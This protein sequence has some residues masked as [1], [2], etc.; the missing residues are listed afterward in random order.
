MLT[1]AAM[2]NNSTVYIC[3]LS[4]RRDQTGIKN[5]YSRYGK[6]K[7]IKIITDPKTQNSRGMA[8]VEMENAVHAKLAIDGL[9]QQ[10]IDGRTLKANYATTPIVKVTRIEKSENLEKENNY[11]EKQLAKKAQRH[12]RRK[13]GYLTLKSRS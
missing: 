3:N 12:A 13:P 1:K 2:K 10:V 7:S 8:F 5:L 6:I 4:Y 11:I 9:N